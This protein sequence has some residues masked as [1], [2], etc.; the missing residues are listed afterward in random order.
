MWH[1]AQTANPNEASPDER[2]CL[3]TR[4]LTRADDHLQMALFE[5]FETFQVV[6]HHKDPPD[7]KLDI[8]KQILHVAKAMNVDDV[9]WI[10]T[11]D[12]GRSFSLKIR[13]Y[14]CDRVPGLPAA[15]QRQAESCSRDL[16]TNHPVAA[17]PRVN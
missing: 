2:L 3:V 17:Q 15:L 16:M 8:Q 4:R 6:R 12:D 5:L 9:A 14:I 13:K 7:L 10:I 11:R 1:L